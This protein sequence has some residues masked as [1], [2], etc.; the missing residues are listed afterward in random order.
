M[1]ILCMGEIKTGKCVGF[2][3]HNLLFGYQRPPY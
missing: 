1:S 3:Q 2:E